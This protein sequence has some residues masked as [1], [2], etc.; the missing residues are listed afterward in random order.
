MLLKLE[1]INQEYNMDKPEERARIMKDLDNLGFFDVEVYNRHKATLASGAPGAEK[2]IDF[3]KDVRLFSQAIY[4]N[5]RI[6]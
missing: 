3:L 4:R 6:Q 2:V 1:V 5:R